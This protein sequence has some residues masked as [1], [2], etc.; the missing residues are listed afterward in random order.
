MARDFPAPF[1]IIDSQS[2]L[3]YTSPWAGAHNRWIP[4]T[5]STETRDHE[6]ALI[7]FEHMEQFESMG[8]SGEAGITFMKGIE[9]L[10]DPPQQYVDLTNDKA[11]ALGM[12]EFRLLDKK[13][14]LPPGVEWGCEYRT[15]CVNP[16]MYCCF[17]L[18][19]FVFLGGKTLKRE[20]RDPSEIFAMDE[21]RS[22]KKVINCSGVG[23]GDEKV[24][25]TRG[26]YQ[27]CGAR[28]TKDSSS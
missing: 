14:E 15:W 20:V 19:Q 2:Q 24:F 6:L 7:T 1:E 5:N 26:L 23:F 28:Y 12:K 3:N 22:V 8:K 27:R 25:P 11:K 17:L 18:R 9:Y 21:F 4:P 13:T 10:E 16:M